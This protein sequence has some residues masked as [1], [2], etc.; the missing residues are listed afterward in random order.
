[1]RPEYSGRGDAA[2]SMDLL[3]GRRPKPTRGPTATLTVEAIVRA[4]TDLADR[5]GLDALS[6]RRV[7]DVLGV[8][9]M[10]LYTHVPGKGELLDLMLDTVYGEIADEPAPSA[11][12]GG[13]ADGGAAGW[14]AALESGARRQWALHERHPWTLYIASSRAVLGPNE[15]TSYEAALSRVADLG[16][17]ARDAVAMAD[18]LAMFVR[19][20][21]RDAV[22]ARGAAVVTGTSEEDWWREREPILEEVLDPERFPTTIR[23]GAEGGFS[24]PDDAP[25]YN[26]RFVLDDFEFGLQRLLDG[27]EAHVERHGSPE[28]EAG[29]GPR[30]V[31]GR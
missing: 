13:A 6:M 25:N 11:A 17:I 31:R 7:A 23:L 18:S 2:R 5:D 27:F 1:M 22:E 15:L 16:L 14:R 9:T 8:G 19:G 4:A 21:A 28:S 24:V 3:W 12:G 10:T 30:A 20:A 29:E 26:E